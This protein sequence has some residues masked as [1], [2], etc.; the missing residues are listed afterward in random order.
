[1]R[2]VGLA[3]VASARLHGAAAGA[4]RQGRHRCG[5]RGRGGGEAVVVE[6][7]DD[8]MPVTVEEDDADEEAEVDNCC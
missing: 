1:M 7:D 5:R 2:Q 3:Q 8:N 4:A 6:E